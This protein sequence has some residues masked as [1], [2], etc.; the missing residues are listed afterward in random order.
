MPCEECEDGKV[1]WGKTGSCKYDSIAECEADNKDYYEEEKTTSIVE[2]IIQDDNQELAIDAISLVTAPAIEQDFVFFGKEK[3]NLTFAKVDEE[4]RMLISPALIP[5]KTIF[6]H[7]PQT[8]SDYFVFFSKATVRKASELYLKHNNHHKA[9]Y[10]HQDR[11]SGILT[12]ES[13]II[14]DSKLDKSTLYGFSLPV[15]TWMVKLKIDND[16]IWS[17]IKD[18]ELKGLSIEGYFTN[19]FEQMNKT[20]ET[21]TEEILSAFNELVR[22]GKITTMSKAKRLELGLAD[23]VEKLTQQAKALIP[24]LKRD[25]DG[26]K[27]STKNVDTEIKILSKRESILDKA[28]KKERELYRALD[29]A[30]D[31]LATAEREVKESEGTLQS[32]KKTIDFLNKRLDKTKSK[33]TKVKSNLAKKL[34]ALEKAA[35]DLGVKIP[36]GQASQLLNKLTGLL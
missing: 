24:D 30:K 5:G 33:A 28:D 19:K 9:T 7:D 2:L 4:K 29:K 14:E 34:A 25:I 16:E 13:W 12:V 17:K 1:K 35:K 21:T 3:N 22:E 23:D 31:I 15:G 18:G 20:K 11:I 32:N 8:S 26:I 6:R 36:T 27:D 10:Q